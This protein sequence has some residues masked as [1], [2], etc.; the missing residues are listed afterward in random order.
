MEDKDSL[1]SNEEGG[2]TDFLLALVRTSRIKERQL[3]NAT[4]LD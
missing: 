1:D 3:H 4:H 2:V